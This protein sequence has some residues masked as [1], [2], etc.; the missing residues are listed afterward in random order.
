MSRERYVEESSAFRPGSRSKLAENGA[1]NIADDAMTLQRMAERNVT[2]HCIDVAAPITAA[3]DHPGGFEIDENLRDGTLGHSN[4]FGE[5]TE[6]QFGVLG[7]SNRNVRVV[8]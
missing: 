1:E 6:P 3:R 8:A 4:L 5:V 7:E 2:V